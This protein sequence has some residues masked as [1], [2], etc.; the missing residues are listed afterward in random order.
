MD[1]NRQLRSKILPSFASHLAVDHLPR[2]SV[3]PALARMQKEMNV[4]WHVIR[5]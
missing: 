1:G 3:F 5:S 4:I 2:A